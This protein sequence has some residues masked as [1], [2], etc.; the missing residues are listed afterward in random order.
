[1]IGEVMSKHE[2]DDPQRG[3]G[4]HAG[5]LIVRSDHAAV[6]SGRE[7]AESARSRELL[8]R[9]SESERKNIN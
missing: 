5:L 6:E 1:M 9:T 4:R 2:R 3:H 7:R 8:V